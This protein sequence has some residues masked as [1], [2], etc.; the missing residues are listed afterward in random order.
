[1]AQVKLI[2]HY[3]SGGGITT[4]PLPLPTAPVSREWDDSIYTPGQGVLPPGAIPKAIDPTPLSYNQL[5]PVARGSLSQDERN[6]RTSILANPNYTSIAP[7]RTGNPQTDFM[8]LV[9]G[10][11]PSRQTLADV[12]P[13]FA[14]WYPGSSFDKADIK[15]SWGWADV[16]GNLDSNNP[17]WQWYN[18][19]GS[20][21]SKK[22]P[23]LTSSY[24]AQFSDPLTKQYERLLAQQT[25]LYKRQQAEMAEEAARKQAV[26]AETDVAVKRL[27]DFLNKR[28]TNLEQPAYTD[29]EANVIKTRLLDPLEADRTATRN[30]TLNNI[31]SRGFDPTSG[32]AQQMFQDVDRE[33]DKTRSRV[34][35]DVAYEQIQE[36]RS[37]EQEAQ[38]LL[39]YLTQLPTAAARGDLDFVNYLDNLVSSRGEQALGTSALSADLPVQRTQLALQ[40][41]GLGGQPIN[42]I[43]GV[44]GLLQNSQNNRLYNNQNTSNF[45]RNIG[46]SF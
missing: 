10:L 23:A 9:N 36:E 26:R 24:S 1:M 46:M 45:W 41:L 32:I 4:S 33:Y 30:R 40:T 28:V 38:E 27:Q 29:S 8:A 21:K 35:G 43:N 7:K 13:Q 3:R 22:N 37:R 18:G 25:D 20:S 19:A 15:G 5:T 34:H 16:I 6:N 11:S 31:G 12:F 14:E 42:S 39:K 44:L 2:P 17:K